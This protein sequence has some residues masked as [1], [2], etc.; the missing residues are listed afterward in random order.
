MSDRRVLNSWKEIA[1]YVGRGVRTIQRYERNLSFP[2]RRVAGRARTSVMAFSDEIDAWLS[3]SSVGLPI[4][5]QN[6]NVHSDGGSKVPL[7]TST[8]D[9]LL[10]ATDPHSIWLVEDDV[11]YVDAFRAAL[12]L[13]GPYRVTVFDTSS[14]AL[15][16][17]TDLERGS[18]RTPVLIV[19]DYELSGS[20]GFEV[21]THYRNSP[22]L[23]AAVPLVVWSILDNVT[24]REMSTWMGAKTFVAKQIG[25]KALMRALASLVR[26]E[27]SRPVCDRSQTMV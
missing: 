10:G 1:Q 21:L 17:I 7:P 8:G 18:L 24:T 19:L 2:V 4:H 26:K 13:L 6:G 14:A 20:S 27:P 12:G 3:R 22:E 16:A 9:T 11:S 5:D 23:K 15:K 25:Q